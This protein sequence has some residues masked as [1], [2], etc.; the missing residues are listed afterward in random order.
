MTN[1]LT[2]DATKLGP[3]GNFVGDLLTASTPTGTTKVYVWNGMRWVPRKCFRVRVHGRLR[4]TTAYVEREL[5]EIC[6]I[7][8]AHVLRQARAQHAQTIDELSYRRYVTEEIQ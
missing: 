7:D 5:G 4:R 8:R 3:R 6:G 2:I 1:K